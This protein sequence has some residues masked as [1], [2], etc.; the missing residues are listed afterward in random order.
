MP[1]PCV[2]CGKRET[3]TTEVCRHC[4]QIGNVTMYCS[5][6]D[7][8]ITLEPHLIDGLKLILFA[9]GKDATRINASGD[10]G[11]VIKLSDCPACRTCEGKTNYQES[12]T[13][14]FKIV[15]LN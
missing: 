5:H 13:I 2:C 3:D 6:C 14:P 10:T 9:A 7:T 11:T 12:E 4:G 1:R 15:L 8:I